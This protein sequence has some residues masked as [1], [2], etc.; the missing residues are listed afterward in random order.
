MKTPVNLNAYILGLE[1]TV[2]NLS[3]KVRALEAVLD[4]ERA[5]NEKRVREME[6]RIVSLEADIRRAEIEKNSRRTSF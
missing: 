6:G 3:D 4:K 1:I 2:R 5:Q